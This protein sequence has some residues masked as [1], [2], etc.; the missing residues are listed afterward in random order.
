MT[1]L[2]IPADAQ[3]FGYAQLSEKFEEFVMFELKTKKNEN[4]M[5]FL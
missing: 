2:L 1:F 3:K 5:Q 4:L